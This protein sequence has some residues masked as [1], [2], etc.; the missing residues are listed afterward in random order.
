VTRL[1]QPSPALVI[2][3][4]ALFVAL[5][6]GAY[7]A[8]RVGSKQIA[9]NS[10]RSKD[11]RNNQLRGKDVRNRSLSGRDIALDSLAGPQIDE[12]SLGRVPNAGNA[13]ALQGRRRV[14]V[15]P[16]TLAN[17][18]AREVMREG[19]FVL[20]ARCR[21]G[22]AMV[23]GDRDVAEVLIASNVANAA[24]DAAGSGALGPGTAEEDRVFVN[25]VALPGEVAVDS[26]QDALALAPDG[27]EEIVDASL[28]AA[29]NALGQPRTCRFGGYV[30]LG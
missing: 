2:A 16:F 10:I 26:L 9:N 20:T 8:L 18:Q 30:D 3:V 6:G 5:G 15:P 12:P 13:Q 25:A 19:P 14:G 27:T 23:D 1:R 11:V 28:Y 24:F 7:A 29:V 17:G 4:I 21:I 22:V